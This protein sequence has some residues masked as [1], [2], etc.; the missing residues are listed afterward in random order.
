VRALAG[1]GAL[2]ERS[3]CLWAVGMR[4][5]GAGAEENWR[6]LKGFPHIGQKE[7]ASSAARKH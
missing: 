5:N 4:R 1:A 6:E 7:R 3:V 2:P